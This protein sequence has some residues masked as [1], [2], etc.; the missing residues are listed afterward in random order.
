MAIRDK[1]LTLVERIKHNPEGIR[2]VRNIYQFDVSGADSGVYQLKF[3][4]GHVQ[5]S[6]KVVDRP[7]CILQ[8]SDENLVKLVKGELN[9]AMAFMT[10]KVKVKGEVALALK[11]QSIL[12]QYQ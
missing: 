12:K 5:F 6:D 1:F 8:I 7:D 10:G 3:K 2:G 9:P 4:D 11:L